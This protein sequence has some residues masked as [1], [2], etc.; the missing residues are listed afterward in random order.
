VLTFLFGEIDIPVQGGFDVGGRVSGG[1]DDD[2][3]EVGV[4]GQKLA[5]EVGPGVVAVARG[6]ADVYD[7]GD[8]G[9][10]IRVGAPDNAGVFEE[11][12]CAFGVQGA[13]APDVEAGVCVEDWKGFKVDLFA[14]SE[15]GEGE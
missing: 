1:A 9:V 13:W 15:E 3:L 6:I 5:L 14:G 4:D 7:A 10:G 12:R 11:E 2:F 8:V